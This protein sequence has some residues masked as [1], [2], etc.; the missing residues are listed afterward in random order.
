MSFVCRIKIRTRQFYINQRITH[1][2][3][4]KVLKLFNAFFPFL[5]NGKVEKFAK[6]TAQ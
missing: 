5:D 2:T 6:L 3:M 1:L 4:E